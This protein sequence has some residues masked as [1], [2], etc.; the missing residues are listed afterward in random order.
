M[1][2]RVVCRTGL[3]PGHSY[4]PRIRA[5]ASCVRVRQDRFSPD[6][7]RIRARQQVADRVARETSRRLR[8]RGASLAI[9]LSHRVHDRHDHRVP[10]L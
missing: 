3:P 10:R 9:A 4:S 1:D 7:A 2:R 6:H 8:G 5:W